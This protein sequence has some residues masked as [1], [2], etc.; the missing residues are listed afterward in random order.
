LCRCRAVQSGAAVGRKEERNGGAGTSVV[1]REDEGED[2]DEDE[3][4]RRK[5]C[6]LRSLG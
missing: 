5:S 4:E 1:Q 6:R 3:D 2:E